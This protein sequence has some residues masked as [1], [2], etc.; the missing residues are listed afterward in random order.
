MPA[1]VVFGPPGT[2]ALVLLALG[3]SSRGT[4]QL[5]TSEASALRAA[6]AALPSRCRV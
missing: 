1:R 2:L 6:S 3:R 4:E 5:A